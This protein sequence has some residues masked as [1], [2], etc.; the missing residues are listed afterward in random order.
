MDLALEQ[1]AQP[2]H[3]PER[4]RELERGLEIPQ[5]GGE[6][7]EAVTLAARLGLAVPQGEAADALQVREGQVRRAVALVALLEVLLADLG[8]RL[9][10]VR[11]GHPAAGGRC[12]VDRELAHERELLT[13]RRPERDLLAEVA[14]ALI[15]RHE[16]DGDQSG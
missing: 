7:L 1:V 16:A 6:H 2:L 10:E 4:A 11:E 14:G 3:R 12:E 9:V 8:E 15:R 5:L 13:L